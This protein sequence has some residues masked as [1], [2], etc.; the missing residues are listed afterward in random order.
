MGDRQENRLIHRFQN[1]PQNF[2]NQLVCEC[3]DSQRP[4]FLK[5]ILFLD[6]GSSNGCGLVGFICE[7]LNDIC[8]FGFAE[9]ICRVVIC[10]LGCGTAVGI[11]VFIL[12]L[13]KTV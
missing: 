4:L 2:L 13:N 1:H 5:I 11:Q 6:I 12:I 7:P 8:D 3:R 10:T 9:S